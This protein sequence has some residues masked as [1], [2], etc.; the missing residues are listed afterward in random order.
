MWQSRWKL[1]NWYDLCD[2]NVSFWDLLHWTKNVWI[3][4]NLSLRKYLVY[5]L[6][7]FLIFIFSYKNVYII[8]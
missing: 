4:D 2:Q 7:I 3:V 8:Y 6:K 5:I 1:L